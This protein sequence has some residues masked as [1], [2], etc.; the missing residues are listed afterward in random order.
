MRCISCGNLSFRVLCRACQLSIKPS[1]NRRK[2]KDDFYVYSFFGY[3]EISPL[4]HTKHHSCGAYIYK[5]L[6][7]KAFIPFLQ[8]LHVRPLHVVPVDDKPKGA[9]S[10]TAILARAVKTKNIRPFYNCL[11]A[12]SEITYS[13]KSLKYRK[14]NP[15]NFTCK[16]PVEENIIFIDDLVTTGTTLL[17]ALHVAKK[18]N[19]NPLFALTLAD[20][21]VKY[22]IINQII[23]I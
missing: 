8:D 22:G 12:K 3:N 11:R 15:R 7:Q 9:Y 17:E 1:P 13:G 14:S 16:I 5:F 2:L 10:H 4:L 19:L 21:K 6:A 23:K 18:S 20:A